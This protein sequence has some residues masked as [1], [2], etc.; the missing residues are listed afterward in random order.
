MV[1]PTYFLHSRFVDSIYSN[2]QFKIDVCT[3]VLVQSLDKFGKELTSFPR[4]HDPWHAFNRRD[5][6]YAREVHLSVVYFTREQSC[7]V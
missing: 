1:V 2:A 3:R 7:Y 4:T 6:L 5:E